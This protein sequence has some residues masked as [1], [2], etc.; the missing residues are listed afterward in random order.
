MIFAWQIEYNGKVWKADDLTIDQLSGLAKE[1]KI[2]WFALQPR[3]NLEHLKAVV[4]VMNEANEGVAR[5]HTRAALGALK[6]AELEKIVVDAEDDMPAEYVD[7][8]PTEGDPS[9]ITS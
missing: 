3:I 8:N 6:I 2:D 9:T 7:G 4:E 1:L 5:E